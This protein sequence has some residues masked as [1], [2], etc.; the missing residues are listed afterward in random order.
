MGRNTRIILDVLAAVDIVWATW[1]FLRAWLAGD[2]DV[3][4]WL[5]LT[6]GF[7]MQVYA[8]LIA[9]GLVI[10]IGANWRWIDARR[11]KTRLVAL[12]PDI[13]DAM[14]RNLWDLTYS[15]EQGVDPP[16]ASSPTR[17]KIIK[18]AYALDDL[19]VPH[20]PLKGTS[21]LFMWRRFLPPIL[22]A[23]EIG[24][25]SRARKVWDETR[26]PTTEGK[27]SGENQ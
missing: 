8:G 7:A 9:G 6:P 2:A 26:G 23:A 19:K 24:S 3:T 1:G 15:H 22:A 17:S 11:S 20:P 14:D 13:R 12:G 21:A 25:M 10:L 16:V 27:D 18:V 4:P 5:E